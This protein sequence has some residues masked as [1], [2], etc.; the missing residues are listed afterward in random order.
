MDRDDTRGTYCALRGQRGSA[1]VKA[2]GEFA[3]QNRPG[4]WNPWLSF[5]SQVRRVSRRI[6]SHLSRAL[7]A[8]SRSPPIGPSGLPPERK[9]QLS[10]NRPAGI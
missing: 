10:L 5:L 6:R 2:Y 8:L 4:R 7:T 3:A 9:L 1:S